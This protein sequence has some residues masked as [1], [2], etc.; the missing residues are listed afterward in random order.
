MQ[1]NGSVGV[2]GRPEPTER[3]AYSF[4]LELVFAYLLIRIIDVRGWLSPLFIVSTAL[5]LCVTVIKSPGKWKECEVTSV[6]SSQLKRDSHLIV[7]YHHFQILS[8]YICQF[9]LKGT[10]S[11]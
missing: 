2:W 3:A 6:G 11:R 4:G 9:S 5:L 7:K 10:A 1:I 8:L